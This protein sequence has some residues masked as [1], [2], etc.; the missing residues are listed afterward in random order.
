[1]PVITKIFSGP[2]GE[3]KG[4]VDDKREKIIKDTIMELKKEADKSD[5]NDY[6]RDDQF[7]EFNPT[8][9]IPLLA[10]VF[11]GLW[12]EADSIK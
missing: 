4:K 5:G 10:L 9:I 1:M 7:P 6:Y 8:K 3:D 2:W 12:L 11:A